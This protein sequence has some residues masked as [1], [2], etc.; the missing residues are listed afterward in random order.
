MHSLMKYLVHGLFQGR[1]AG[2]C[3]PALTTWTL[4]PKCEAALCPQAQVQELTFKVII[5]PV[6]LESAERVKA[7]LKK[8][9]NCHWRLNEEIAVRLLMICSKS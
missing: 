9:K 2:L 7:S 5:I 4:F 8:L 1:A 6:S 3:L